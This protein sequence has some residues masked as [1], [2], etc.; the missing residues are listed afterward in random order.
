MLLP[1][2]ATCCWFWA[3]NSAERDA[4][5]PEPQSGP[6]PALPPEDWDKDRNN[7]GIVCAKGPQ[8]SNSHFNVKDDQLDDALAL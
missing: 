3:G 7:N 5:P 2:V 1:T 8:G 6:V 4:C